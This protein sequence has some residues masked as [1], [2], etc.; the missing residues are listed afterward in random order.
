MA[1]KFVGSFTQRMD[2]KG[3]VSIPASF[4]RVIETSDPAWSNGQRPTFNIAYGEEGRPYLEGYS[5]AGLEE[6]HDKIDRMTP[7]SAARE[8]ME[9][10]YYSCVQEFTVDDDGRIVLSKEL[11]D[12]VGLT[13]EAMFVAKGN[14]FEIWSPEVHAARRASKTRD[15]LAAQGSDFNPHALLAAETG[16][17]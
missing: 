15:F 8:V 14:R 17:E 2:G 13:G 1:R 7:G 10:L 5:V 11:R 4:R 12:R 16:G 6:M 3:R 9:D